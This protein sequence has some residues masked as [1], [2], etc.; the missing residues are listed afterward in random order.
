MPPPKKKVGFVPLE[1]KMFKMVK[2]EQLDTNIDYAVTINPPDIRED[3]PLLVHLPMESLEKGIDL[4][5]NLIRKSFKSAKLKLY[6]ELSPNGRL[7]YHGTLRVTD[8]FKFVF[9][10]CY[11]FKNL[12]NLEID[13]ISDSKVWEEYCTKQKTKMEPIITQ[14]SYNYPLHIGPPEAA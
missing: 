1:H 13:T 11:Y 12:F 6:P 10:D 7:H 9:I 4:S 3:C 8:P 5:T 2:F 14:M